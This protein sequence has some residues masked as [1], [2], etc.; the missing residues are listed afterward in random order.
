MKKKMNFE[1]MRDTTKTM[2]VWWSSNGKST[3][4]YIDKIDDARII[5]DVLA[6][7][8]V[9]DDSVILNM[10]DVEVLEDGEWSSWYSEDGSSTDEY[11]KEGE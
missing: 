6:L 8:E 11:F 10:S 9:D 1:S 7:R 4:Y 5:L 3:Y 2:R